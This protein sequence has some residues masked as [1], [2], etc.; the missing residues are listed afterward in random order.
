MQR[1]WYLALGQLHGWAEQL[2]RPIQS[3]LL[4]GSEKMTDP[5]Q[6]II[7]PVLETEIL[8]LTLAWRN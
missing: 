2:Q 7:R 8:P 4:M 3:V 6:Q 5:S 1:S